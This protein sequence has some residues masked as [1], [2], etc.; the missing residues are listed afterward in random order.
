M[1]PNSTVE[2]SE[3]Q[4]LQLMRIIES[5]ED[6]DDVQQV[7]SNLEVSEGAVELLEVA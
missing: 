6:L 1:I 3:E 5:V 4:T 7:F 2:L